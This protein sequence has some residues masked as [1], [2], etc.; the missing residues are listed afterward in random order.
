M[1][2]SDEP[3]AVALIADQAFG[4]GVWAIANEHDVWIVDSEINR[5]AVETLWAETQ[6]G[7][8]HR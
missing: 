8:R 2:A 3:Y 1:S 4:E 6:S 5:H 7:Q